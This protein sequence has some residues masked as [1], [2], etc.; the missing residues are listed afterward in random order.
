MFRRFRVARQLHRANISAPPLEEANYMAVIGGEER[1]LTHSSFN[2]AWLAEMGVTPGTILELGSYDGGDGYRFRKAFPDALIVSVEA[3]PDRFQIVDANLHD[4]RIRVHHLA[5]CDSDGSIDWYP[6]TIEGKAHGQGSLFRHSDKYR[7]KFS[8]VHQS[9]Q[10]VTV[11]AK[12]LDTLCR[13]EG[14]KKIDLLHMDIEGA[15]RLALIGLGD[16]RP[17]IIYLEMRDNFFVGAGSKAETDSLLKGM[18]Y[19]MIVNLGT[20]RMYRFAG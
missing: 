15:E 10:P 3:D 4:S 6:A 5:V 7:R 11:A 18:G 9:S 2:P 16:I 12:R 1:K 13:D 20:D 17:S 14:I 19:E 8:F